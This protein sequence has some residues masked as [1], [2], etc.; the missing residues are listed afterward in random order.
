MKKISLNIVLLFISILALQGQD[1]R[2]F[3]FGLQPDITWEIKDNE[4]NTFSINILPLVAQVYL[5]KASAIRITSIVNREI[6]SKKISNVGVQLALPIYFLHKSGHRATGVYA[7]PVLG[8][9]KNKL[10]TGKEFTIAVEPGYSWILEKG[11]S[12]NLGLQLGGSYFTPTDEAE[13]WRNHTGLKFSLGYTFH[14]K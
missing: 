6:S 4:E 13:G 11:F 14:S 1:T 7:S 9:S 2:L 3:F 10:S 5:N 8:L 12:M